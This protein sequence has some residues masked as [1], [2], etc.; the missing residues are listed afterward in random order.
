MFNC[1]II[2]FCNY[3]PA[4]GRRHFAR[5]NNLGGET[6]GPSASRRVKWGQAREGG[7]T[8]QNMHMMM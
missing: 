7:Q 2:V 5:R 4:H 8:A 3:L 6:N 1:R